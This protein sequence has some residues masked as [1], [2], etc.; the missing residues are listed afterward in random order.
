M[1]V[2]CLR[3]HTRIRIFLFFIKAVLAPSFIS[4]E[5]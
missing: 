1:S 4:N 3:G 5:K 2:V